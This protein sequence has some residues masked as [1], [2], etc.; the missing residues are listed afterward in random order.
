MSP[1][2]RSIIPSTV[3]FWNG[4][5]R[6]VSRAAGVGAGAAG[7]T[8]VSSAATGISAAAT[9]TPGLAH[10][11]ASSNSNPACSSW[12]TRPASS[13]KRISCSSFRMSY[14][15]PPWAASR[16]SLYSCVSSMVS[17]WTSIA[18]AGVSVAADVSAAAGVSAA[19]TVSGVTAA[20]ISSSATS[21]SRAMS[22]ILASSCAVPPTCS[23]GTIRIGPD[24]APPE[25]MPAR[26]AVALGR[27]SALFPPTED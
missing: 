15:D 7:T 25:L 24:G 18:A 14:T 4:K 20:T 6:E 5:V 22:G 2:S 17:G 21:V 9:A 8:G 3:R 10:P 12:R 23:G 16:V 19:A 26:V 27:S 11:V 1:V 13:S